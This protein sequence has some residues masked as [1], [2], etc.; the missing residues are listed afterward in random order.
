MARAVAI[1][2]EKGPT[3]G[4]TADEGPVPEAWPEVATSEE[5]RRRLCRPHSQCMWLPPRRQC[6]RERSSPSQRFTTQELCSGLS[7]SMQTSVFAWTEDRTLQKIRIGSP[8]PGPEAE[9]CCRSSPALT[10]T[11]DLHFFHIRILARSQLRHT[12][13]RELRS[14]AT[15]HCSHSP[16]ASKQTGRM[17]QPASAF[18]VAKLQ[19]RRRRQEQWRSISAKGRG[20]DQPLICN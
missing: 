2:N 3:P 16:L 15:L 7:S 19:Q 9:T 13:L 5:A 17:V 8:K 20:Q 11:F 14:C 6:G 1:T 12:T 4:L 18:A 10:S